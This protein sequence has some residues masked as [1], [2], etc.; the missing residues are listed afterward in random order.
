MGGPQD[1]QRLLAANG[2][3]PARLEWQ[4]ARNSWQMCEIDR[5]GTTGRICTI[6]QT[7]K[8]GIKSTGC[9]RGRRPQLRG[10]RIK[11]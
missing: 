8:G 5:L 6:R 1:A 3:M 11:L 4:P 2:A 10:A 9:R 7:F